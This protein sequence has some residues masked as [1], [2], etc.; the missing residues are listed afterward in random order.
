MPV[1][2][3]ALSG[4]AKSLSLS[5]RTGSVDS[6]ASIWFL[7]IGKSIEE[8]LSK[9]T[10]VGLTTYSGMLDVKHSDFAIDLSGIDEAE[11]RIS[12]VTKASQT[13]INDHPVEVARLTEP[14]ETALLTETVETNDPL[15]II[16]NLAV[17]DST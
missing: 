7:T 12:C 16:Y 8:M 9:H 2:I 15:D 13:W 10:A 11:E 4:Q 14:V 6:Q 1:N 5:D 3:A 17:S